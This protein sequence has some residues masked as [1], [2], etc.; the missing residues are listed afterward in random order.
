MKTHAPAAVQQIVAPR[1]ACGVLYAHLPRAEMISQTSAT[2]ELCIKN[3]RAPVQGDL[4]W[5]SP[6]HFPA[7]K[8]PGTIAWSEHVEAWEAYSKKWGSGQSAERIAERQGFGYAELVELL[9][10]EPLTWKS[11]V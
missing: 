3:R 6:R 5:S 10:R 9:G 1:T 8:P 11:L 4:G 7:A 2:C